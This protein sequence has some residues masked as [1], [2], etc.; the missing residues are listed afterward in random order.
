MLFAA[1]QG[2]VK[3][4]EERVEEQRAALAERDERT[5]DLQ[6]EKESLEDELAAKEERIDD[7]E[8]RLETVE[9]HLGMATT[10]SSPAVADD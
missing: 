9:A 1:V 6:E 4:L 2:L 7:L 10:E 8:T 3:R 5:D